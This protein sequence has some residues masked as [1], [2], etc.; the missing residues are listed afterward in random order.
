MSESQPPESLYKEADS[1]DSNSSRIS[2]RLK[3]SGYYT[4]DGNKSVSY[5]GLAAPQARGTSQKVSP[6]KRTR[7]KSPSRRA[8]S[9]ARRLTTEDRQPKSPS[10]KQSAPVKQVQPK[11]V[12][13][14]E[15]ASQVLL[16]K[17]A[18]TSSLDLHKQLREQEVRRRLGNIRESIDPEGTNGITLKKINNSD[19]EKSKTRRRKTKP[20]LQHSTPYAENRNKSS[21]KSRSQD[22]LSPK[23]AMPTS[24]FDASNISQHIANVRTPEKKTPHVS[25][26]LKYAAQNNQL[27]TNYQPENIEEINSREGFLNKTVDA[28]KAYAKS[29]YDTAVIMKK[30]AFRSAGMVRQR[31]GIHDGNEPNEPEVQTSSSPNNRRLAVR[32][33]MR[34][35]GAGDLTAPDFSSC[36]E[37]MPDEVKSKR[38][39][40]KSNKLVEKPSRLDETVTNRELLR[41]AK[42][43]GYFFLAYFVLKV[44]ILKPTQEN[45]STTS[46]PGNPAYQNLLGR[47]EI[48]KLVNSA[49]ESHLK[50]RLQQFENRQDLFETHTIDE[51]FNNFYNIKIL[52]QLEANNYKQLKSV[53]DTISVKVNSNSESLVLLKSHLS[54]LDKRVPE[55][56]VT[57]T[58]NNQDLAELKTR[59]SQFETEIKNNALN[60]KTELTT[61][62]QLV[63]TTDSLTK[64]KLSENTK[65]FAAQLDTI[66]K[67]LQ[68]SAE[69]TQKSLEIKFDKLS[70]V[71]NSNS[72]KFSKINQEMDQYV[73]NQVQ[74]MDKAR[75]NL[76][77]LITENKKSSTIQNELIE[78]LKIENEKL[79]ADQENLVK[80]HVGLK[81][82]HDH[83]TK[84]QHLLKQV[85]SASKCEK[86][87]KDTDVRANFADSK[88]ASV[89]RERCSDNAETQ[90]RYISFLGL[91]IIR[92]EIGPTTALEESEGVPGNC[93]AFSGQEGVLSFQTNQFITPSYL[94]ID[95]LVGQSSAP[96]EFK[97]YGSKNMTT[98]ET[99]RT[100]LGQFTLIQTA[101]TESIFSQQT[102]R[103]LLE[104][105][106]SNTDSLDSSETETLETKKDDNI[107]SVFEIE[108]LSNYGNEQF[109]CIYQVK[110]H[111]SV[112]NKYKSSELFFMEEN[113]E[114]PYNFVDNFFGSK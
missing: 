42:W 69:V 104:T 36:D 84:Q 11:V 88:V 48:Q 93:W 29:A 65:V 62:K 9:P 27:E 39:N 18:T 58:E 87:F 28:G 17:S 76:E 63:D 100:S 90:V 37:T 68:K 32:D 64:G 91:P 113:V 10:R 25:N 78:N 73:K 7:S 4:E 49:M 33:M 89:I 14:R 109:T 54:A 79:K 74:E 30:Y 80:K 99:E 111:G 101:S 94:T 38:R 77:K 92:E 2:S 107:F 82:D 67:K 31:R 61:F 15:S 83:L 66:E 47:S 35:Q 72:E 8:A 1:K 96:K 43:V 53:L 108:F 59:I 81:Q 5:K 98:L 97:I 46:S 41:Y 56:S 3:Q 40:S 55:M 86:S 21:E 24:I 23:I 57:I 6:G 44:F 114:K 70:L 85:K 103:I 95:Y 105:S 71:Q 50:P 22:D 12:L 60:L 112:D 16:P 75:T 52:P 13:P 110:V 51:K 26:L 34:E 106:A 20:I 102:F 45:T 19:A